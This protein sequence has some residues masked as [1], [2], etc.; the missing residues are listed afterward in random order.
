MTTEFV[1]KIFDEHMPFKDKV[2]AVF[3]HQLNNNNV[4]RKW[5]GLLNKKWNG[6]ITNIP[7]LPISFFKTLN[8]QTGN[9]APQVVFESSSTT[10][11]GVSRHYVSDEQ[12]YEG[13]FIKAFEM[14]YGDIK[15]WC[16]I[17]LLPSY[18]ERQHS[19]L[20]YMVNKMI[21]K[22]GHAESGFYLNDTEKLHNVLLRL[23]ASNQKT[24]LV[25]VTFALIDFAEQYTMHLNN[26]VVMETGG[27]KGRGKEITRPAM[28]SFIKEK[29][30][31]KAVH[32]EYGMTELLSQAYSK[33]DGVFYC[34]PWMKVLV[35]DEEDPLHVT[36]TGR[37]VLNIIDLANINSC[38]FIATDDVGIVYEDGS[39]EVAGRLDNSDMRGCSLLVV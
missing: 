6:S 15:N 3:E 35:R 4:Y 28:H 16:I 8:I 33:S 17:G 27:M 29:L 25:C 32:A 19:S 39:F 36:T 14:F 9:H 18:L 1:N 34:P 20:V 38:A 10:G 5:C 30:G 12:L 22:S 26:T 23:E 37:G 21:D 24:L 31:V 7:F 2:K 11:Q 13:S